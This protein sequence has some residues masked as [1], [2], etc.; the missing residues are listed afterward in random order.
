MENE[1]VTTGQSKRR[2]PAREGVTP[3]MRAARAND[4]QA[5]C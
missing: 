3:L 1:V 5:M 4:I 2:C